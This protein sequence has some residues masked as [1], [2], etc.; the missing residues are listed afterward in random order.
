MR[1]GL[2]VVSDFERLGGEALQPMV[3]ILDRYRLGDSWALLAGAGLSRQFFSLV[4]YPLLGL[5]Y[6]PA[7]SPWRLDVLLPRAV[8]GRL[9]VAE[10]LSLIA[11]AEYEGRVWQRGE[12]EGVVEHA[13]E[14][15]AARIG[16]SARL[17]LGGSLWLEASGGVVALQRLTIGTGE[18]ETSGALEPGAPFGEL[19]LLAVAF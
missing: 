10:G 2:V 18:K 3:Q 13:V 14:S 11:H 7:A 17:A 5:V 4:P 1:P 8:R 16:L 15:G 9:R 19:S 6:A 12:R